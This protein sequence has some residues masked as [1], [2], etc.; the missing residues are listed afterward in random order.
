MKNNKMLK[1]NIQNK[2][3]KENNIK[4]IYKIKK[5]KFTINNKK[6]CKNL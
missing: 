3:N 4:Y 6:A 2:I 5:S 1:I